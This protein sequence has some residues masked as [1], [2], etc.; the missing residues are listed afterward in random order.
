MIGSKFNTPTT[1]K[2]LSEKHASQPR[3]GTPSQAFEMYRSFFISAD[4]KTENKSM[5]C[6]LPC[7]KQNLMAQKADTTSVRHWP[8]RIRQRAATHASQRHRNHSFANPVRPTA[9]TN[10]G[11]HQSISAWGWLPPAKKKQERK[12]EITQIST[13]VDLG[14]S[15]SRAPRKSER[16]LTDAEHGELLRKA[17]HTSKICLYC[18]IKTTDSSMPW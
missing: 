2:R 1:D 6:V 5:L 13:V 9:T 18:V 17:S 7:R 14:P 8:F 3:N 10:K 11:A 15:Q 16:I 4:I 12:N